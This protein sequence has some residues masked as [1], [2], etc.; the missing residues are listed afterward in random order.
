MMR[1]DTS[2]PKTLLIC[3]VLSVALVLSVAGN[4][5]SVVKGQHVNFV[6]LG[7]NG[8]LHAQLGEIPEQYYV[9]VAKLVVNTLGNVTAHTLVEAVESTRPYLLPDVFVRMKATAEHEARTMQ[10]A[11]LSIMTTGLKAIRVKRLHVG[12]WA[13]TR[14]HLRAIRTMFAGAL[15]IDPHE[16]TVIVDIRPPGI[17][18]RRK[19]TR[20]VSIQ[21]LTWPPLKVQDGQFQDFQ[22]KVDRVVDDPRH[23]GR[24]TQ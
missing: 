5:L 14:V 13:Y 2:S 12:Q 4:V 23:R 7:D 11:S 19:T 21:R 1:F 18:R 16:I 10:Q 17:D 9:D 24:I 3:I 22:F 6:W 20:P 15:P 8:D